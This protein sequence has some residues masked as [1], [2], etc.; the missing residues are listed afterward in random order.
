MPL[1]HL[2][3]FALE[4]QWS[5]RRAIDDAV[6]TLDSVNI[7]KR[8]RRLK[9]THVNRPAHRLSIDLLAPDHVSAT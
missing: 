1:T 6:E 7:L 9:R 8:R 3:T 4:K 2:Q 5:Q